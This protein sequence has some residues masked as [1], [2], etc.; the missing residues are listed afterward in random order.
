VPEVLFSAEVL[1][2]GILHPTIHHRLVGFIEGMLQVV[3]A[4]HQPDRNAGPS[5]LGIQPAKPF[6]HQRPINLP[7]QSVQ[8]VALIQN[9]LQSH[10]KQ[11]VNG[12][13]FLLLRSHRIHQK[14]GANRHNSGK[15][16][17]HWKPLQANIYA[18]FKG[19]S[20]ATS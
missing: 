14:S 13:V 10:P 11:V 1:P 20:G 4:H 9:L 5:F 7:G 6:L 18:G 15:F 19:F 8:G 3:Q 17:A 2:V 16:H 12:A